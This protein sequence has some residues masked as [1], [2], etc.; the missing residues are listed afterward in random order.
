MR[1]STHV[2]VCS[3]QFLQDLLQNVH[4]AGR[5]VVLYASGPQELGVCAE[6]LEFRTVLVPNFEGYL[7]IIRCGHG[8]LSFVRSQEQV[9][10]FQQLLRVRRSVG[11]VEV[12]VEV[13]VEVLV[14]KENVKFGRGD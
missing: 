14:W 3:V 8:D 5:D 12:D 6:S 1:T 2:I 10:F 4:M 13:V 7:F 11:H 9:D